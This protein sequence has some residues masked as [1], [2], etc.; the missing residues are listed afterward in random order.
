MVALSFI[1]KLGE[2]GITVPRDLSVA[3]YSDIEYAA[4]ARPS[5]TT[6]RIPVSSL[7]AAGMDIVTGVQPRVSVLLP[8]G[9]KVRESTA[10]PSGR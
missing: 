6:I 8:P 1:R 5:L 2:A 3:S 9:L 7:A 4:L 10:A